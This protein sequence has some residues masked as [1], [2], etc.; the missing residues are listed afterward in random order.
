MWIKNLQTKQMELIER[1]DEAR[2]L[3]PEHGIPSKSDIDKSFEDFMKLANEQTQQSS[4]DFNPGYYVS[5]K[6]LQSKF[7][8][9]GREMAALLP[10]RIR[11]AFDRFKRN[12]KKFLAKI[13]IQAANIDDTIHRSYYKKMDIIEHLDEMEED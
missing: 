2:N 1:I 4:A 10:A 8:F 9:C 11:D 3:F 5:C 12:N 6:S 13:S 7:N